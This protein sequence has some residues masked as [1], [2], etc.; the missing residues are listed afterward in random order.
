[1]K[2]I[3]SL[4]ALA[5]ISCLSATA[6]AHWEYN[7][8]LGISGGYYSNDGDVN[9][10]AFGPAPLFDVNSLNRDIGDDGFVGGFFSG[11]QARCNG[12]L[13]GAELAVDWEDSGSDRFFAGTF[14]SS[15]GVTAPVGVTGVSRYDRG[16]I[17]GLTARAGYA[18][19]S[20][21]LLYVRAGAELS[22]DKLFISVATN[23]TPAITGAF[24]DRFTNTRFVGGVGLE[25]P[26][27]ACFSFRAEY[28]YHSK[29][30]SADTVGLLSDAATLVVADARPNTNSVKASL[31]WN[32]L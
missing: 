16:A 28:N 8:V 20:Y 29:G 30:N 31:V 6:Q 4:L 23:D 15:D 7:S 25:F 14:F 13:F 1:M 18:L 19:T 22:R 2:R 3:K 32:F 24:E 21:V 9:V 12:W 26:I 17:F 27:M 10:T 11:Y 5:A